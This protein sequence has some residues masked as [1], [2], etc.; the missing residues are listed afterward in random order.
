MAGGA[1][2][3]ERMRAFFRGN[4]FAPHRHDQYA[5][6]LTTS[7]VQLFNYRGALRCCLP[8]QCHILHPD[9]LHDGRAGTD[10]GFGYRMLYLEPALVQ[11]AV[12]GGALPF[13]PDPI[14]EPVRDVRRD[15]RRDASPGARPRACHELAALWSL[16]DRLDELAATDLVSLAVGLLCDAAGSRPR[17]D[18]RANLAAVLR[19]RDCLMADPARSPGMAALEHTA[20][21]DRWTLARQFRRVFGTSPSRFRT[22]RQVDGARRL[23]MQGATL[24]EAATAAG[25][26]DQSHLTRQFKRACGLPPG[27]WLTLWRAGLASGGA[28]R[29]PP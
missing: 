20:G 18:G 5:I 23:L 28:G 10:E 25:F 22:L 7:G 9:E 21:I 26:A 27:R 2:G 12:G 17:G 24:A 29:V 19:V 16:D 11:E 8:G 14:R 13:V 3:I 1:P 4:A 6:G 15:A